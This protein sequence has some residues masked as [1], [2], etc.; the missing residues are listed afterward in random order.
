MEGGGQ[1]CFSCPFLLP[2]LCP[3]GLR[4]GK[5]AA[6]TCCS[7]RAEGSRWARLS[8]PQERPGLRRSFWSSQGTAL[9]HTPTEPEGR[10]QGW[11]TRASP[12]PLPMWESIST[13]FS[14]LL[15]SMS[16]EVILFSTARQTPSEVW[17][18]M[19]VEPSCKQPPLHHH[20]Q[21]GAA[22]TEHKHHGAA[23]IPLYATCRDAVSEPDTSARQKARAQNRPELRSVTARS[24]ELQGQSPCSRL[25]VSSSGPAAS[26]QII[27]PLPRATS[28]F[29]A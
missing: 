21:R 12:F 8:C 29:T 23:P 15:G 27:Q 13:I 6:R 25:P 10:A 11:Q 22:T 17:I 3:A 20:A 2:Q 4:P 16:G 1:G 24:G 9:L 28:S 26:G 19:A 7:P 18:P 14:M 5:P